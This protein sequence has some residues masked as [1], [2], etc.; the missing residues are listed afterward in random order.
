ML[1]SRAPGHRG[2]LPSWVGPGDWEVPVSIS[3]KDRVCRLVA[4]MSEPEAADL[5]GS[6]QASPATGMT[7]AE[8]D[9]Y[10]GR[11]V[12]ECRKRQELRYGENPHQAAALYASSWPP[13]GLVGARQLQGPPMSFTN[14]LDAD[15]GMRLVA[16]FE[17]PAAVIIKH[18]NP[19]G[20]AN[21]EDVCRACELAFDCDPRAA[22]GGVVAVNRPVGKDLA[23]LL[24]K[25]FLNV[26]VAPTVAA[27]VA[28]EL[29]ESLRL[30]VVDRPSAPGELDV[31]SIDGGLLLQ[32]HDRLTSPRDWA[33][34]MTRLQPSEEQWHQL[35]TAWKVAR[36]VKSNAVVI[37]RDSMAVGVGA[38]QMSRI[39]AAELAIS[40]AGSRAGGAV[41]AS[42]GLI[43][44]ADVIEALAEAGVGAVIQPGGSV[45]DDD[46]ATAADQSGLSMVSTAERHFRH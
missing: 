46:V 45:G 25:T 44:F 37:V 16:D 11:L 30:L 36:H 39:E 8:S 28:A 24:A 1:C 17:R 14:W 33:G 38:G 31:R 32:A 10:P 7:G 35:L 22:Y 43:P 20:F 2:G 9:G 21:A 23:R 6:L 27:D 5:L 18:T 13:R 34:A 15:A 26:L 29:R 3:N 12:I 19:C 42:D 40:R 41:A 4:E